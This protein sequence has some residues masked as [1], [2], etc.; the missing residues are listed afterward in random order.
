LRTPGRLGGFRKQ[1]NLA[2]VYWLRAPAF[3]VP[4][5]GLTD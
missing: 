4:L 2:A 1:R 3:G 5:K